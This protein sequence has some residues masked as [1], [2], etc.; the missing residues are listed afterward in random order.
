MPAAP[1]QRY[2]A[3]QY[4]NPMYDIVEDDHQY[5]QVESFDAF[6]RRLLQQPYDDRQRE[7]AQGR[8]RLSLAPG[9]STFFNNAAT[10]Q[11][12]SQYQ[13]SGPNVYGGRDHR[14]DSEQAIRRQL[15][16]FAYNNNQNHESSSDVQV[17]PSSSPA[18]RA[19]RRR[20]EQETLATSQ[21]N[22]DTQCF[23]R[24]HRHNR[25]WHDH[26]V[27]HSLGQPPS[28]NDLA[29]ERE[30]QA[31]V[32]QQKQEIVRSSEQILPPRA[33]PCSRDPYQN[34]PI[35]QGIP[36]VAITTLPD[37]L[38]VVF[39][40]PT[41]NAVQSK[42]FDKVY[43]SDD[44]FVLASP[45]GSGKTAILELAICRAVT[46]NA[47]GQY[48][49]IYQAP[50]KALCSERQRDWE[51]KF[52]QIGLKCAE[53]TGDSD[54][55]D[56]R[57]VQ[58]ANIIV[59]TP[60]KWDSIT[61]KWKDHEKLMMLIR[62]FLI[63]EVH[64]LKDDRGAVLE[65][66]VSR[67]KSIGADVRF[68]ALSAT[69]PNFQDVA[70]WLGKSTTEPSVPA[71]YEKF[72]EEFRPVKLKRHVC[73]YVCNNNNDFAFEKSLDARLP[74]VIAKYSEGKP[75]MVF[76]ATRNSTMS[77]A[78][79]ITKWWASKPSRDTMWPLPTKPPALL[80]KD[81]RETVSSGVAFHHAGLDPEDRLQVE[82]GFLTGQ[83]SVICCTSTLAVGVNLPCHLV[84]IKNTVTFTAE[85]LQEY[86][87][88]EMTQML[89]RAG[90]PQFDD[91]AVAVIMTRQ[92]KVRRYNMMVTGQELL[93]SK[94][95]LNLIDHLNA[96]IGLG[97]I[98]DLLSARRWLAGTFLYIRLQRNPENYKLESATSNQNIA[99][100]VDDICFR[101][102]TLLRENNL[103]VGQEYFR[104]TDFGHAM[105]RYY[106]HFD[107][108][109]VFMGLRSRSS[110]S[111][112][113]SAI[114]QA[115][116]FAKIRF[117]QGE[118]HFYKVLNKSP[119]IRWSIPVNLDLPAQ[120]VSLIIQSVLGSADIS[121]DNEMVKHRAQYNTETQIVFKNISGL[122]RCIIDCQICLGD[123]TSIHSALLLERSLGARAW[124]DSPLQMKQIEGIGVVAVRKFV[125]AGIRCMEDL[126]AC[127]PHRIEALVGRNPPFGLKIMEK[128]K[129]FP[130]LRVSLHVLP[131]SIT[132]TPDG[133][134][135]QVKADI[136]FINER[137]TQRF[138][139]RLVYSSLSSGKFAVLILGSG[140]K[141]GPAQSLVFPALLTTTDQS[142]NCYVMCDGI[143]G[144]MRGA[145]V[146]P[147]IVP[148]MFPA[149][150]P[151]E[152]DTSHQPNMSKRRIETIKVIRRQSATSEEFGDDD[153]DDDELMKASIGDLEFDHIENYANPTDIITRK[154]TTRNKSSKPKIV[155]NPT[156][157]TVED[158]DQE[159]VQLANGKWACNHP[160][161]DRNVCKHLC[162]K[163]GM[164]KPPKKKST[165]KRALLPDDSHRPTQKEMSQKGKRTQTKVHFPV[166]KRKS[167]TVIEELDLTRQEKKSK[168][169]GHAMNRPKDFR[170][171]HQLHEIVQGEDIPPTLHSVMNTKPSYCYSQDGDHTL[172][173]MGQS[174]MKSTQASSNYGDIQFERPSTDLYHTQESATPDVVRLNC[175]ANPSDYVE[176]E[177]KA[178]STSRGSEIFGDDDSLLG[179]AMI[180]LADS[181][182]LQT[183]DYDNGYVT[184]DLEDIGYLANEPSYE[185]DDFPMDIDLNSAENYNNPEATTTLTA[186]SLCKG[187]AE[188]PQLPDSNEG[189]KVPT[190][191]DRRS[192][193]GAMLK[194]SQLQEL[195]QPKFAISI[196]QTKPVAKAAEQE[197]EV[198]DLF[199]MFEAQ[200]EDN[201]VVKEKAVPEG[202]TDLEPWLFQ[203]F[204]D[205]VEL[206]DG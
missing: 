36:L 35:V 171:L 60:E 183:T 131:S 51:S 143:A 84:I 152:S 4:D 130:K 1:R 146:K 5:D 72:G 70:A 126:E 30:E 180:G 115:S 11:S 41:F 101:D 166:L 198:L 100:L 66:V 58:S 160:C 63:D 9:P 25:N 57:N 168:A 61:R 148:T 147:Q 125:N 39:P 32:M 139:N 181:Q 189:S 23:E 169:V 193:E 195:K 179:D 170:N 135:I 199:D 158:N 163:T 54:A 73:G 97:T 81:L 138:A 133:V 21:H 205:I 122:I 121:W 186:D 204:G 103:V 78:R 111:E 104:C 141:L 53:L 83:I 197:D 201:A 177:G 136:G 76:C 161:K 2:R 27:T 159:P 118:K 157:C 17:G 116:E 47:T 134:K 114:A 50:T 28:N 92:T 22:P 56:L 7:A 90:R 37:R 184:D 38:R 144:S 108:M 203:E 45:T 3:T 65:A 93:E 95:H 156:S 46:T 85:G 162:C 202:F 172:S 128:V 10:S 20:A 48:K 106:V 150:K 40:F 71:F 176:Y 24:E 206:A 192:P 191:H 112:I 62:V 187:Q 74:E 64:I 175:S 86:S 26:N 110:P 52:G 142:I 105:A 154:N 153:I 149:S 77:T 15:S 49:V 190:L 140:P 124:D 89:G 79:L 34:P 44:N 132:K 200:S 12:Q 98:R 137:P 96:E 16:R 185:D 123:A 87:D 14:D 117:R 19:G 109:K 94:L 196:P 18:L 75:I 31:P 165:T 167:S 91:S 8:G 99:E 68:I 145:T 119:S 29:V 13:A 113:L 42:C 67:M 182:N 173:F 88:L 107:T 155:A 194:G 164:D 6:D 80:N 33:R 43:R 188:K 151:P 129:Q 102:I 120:K 178:P 127:E 55:A 59:T 69:V 174:A 82:K